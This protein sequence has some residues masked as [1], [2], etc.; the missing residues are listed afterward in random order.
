MRLRRHGFT[1]VELLVVIGIISL[2]ISILLPALNAARERA[3]R[4]ACA[5]N[6]RQ[7]GQ[8]LNTY[9]DDNKGKLPQ[10]MRKHGQRYPHA[11]NVIEPEDGLRVMASR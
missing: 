10:T 5:S 7:W 2:L 11:A 4:I 1:L 6:L 9:Y 8:A 3:Q